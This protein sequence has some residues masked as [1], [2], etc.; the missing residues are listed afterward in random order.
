MASSKIV[1]HSLHHESFGQKIKKTLCH[2]KET[3][4][5]LIFRRTARFLGKQQF[6]SS[7]SGHCP[8]EYLLV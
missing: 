1:K 2:I 6:Y 4:I 5:H 3:T 8:V 7:V